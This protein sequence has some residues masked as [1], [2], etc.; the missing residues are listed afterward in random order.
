MPSEKPVEIDRIILGVDPG[1][2]VTGY[3]FL[4][5]TRQGIKI[6]ALGVIKLDRPG[7]DHPQKLSMIYK[8]LLRLIEEFKP[9]EMAIEAP[10]FAKNVQSMLK[11]GRAQGVAMA[12]GLARD[13]PITEYLP[14]K[15]KM[16]VTGNGN[17]SKHQVA[18][19]LRTLLP[20]LTGYG[21]Q[22]ADATDALAVAVTH[23]LQGKKRIPTT[24][25]K[26]ARTKSGSGYSSWGDF[27]VQNPERKG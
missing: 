17:A 16:A 21:E 27:L 9:D 24:P 11:L 5:Q 25:N 10:F 3:G 19:M 14:K 13:V 1:T 7:L 22:L 4:H 6:L 15:V 23:Y 12:A 8:S 20:E 18:A 26:T 2:Q